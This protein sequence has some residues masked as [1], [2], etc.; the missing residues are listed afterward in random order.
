MGQDDP[1]TPLGAQGTYV[2]K[3]WILGVTRALARCWQSRNLPGVP[4]GKPHL[5]RDIGLSSADQA[6]LD[7]QWPSQTVHHPRG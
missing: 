3:S 6:R 7:H 2:Q 5:H 4:R 1:K